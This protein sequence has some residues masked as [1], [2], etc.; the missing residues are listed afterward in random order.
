MRKKLS[1]VIMAHPRRRQWAESLG[2]QLKAPVVYDERSNVWDTC[3]RAWLAQDK[4]AEYGVVIQDDAIVCRDFKRRASKLLRGEPMY[5]FYLTH[6]FLNRAER[7]EREGA[8]YVVSGAVMNEIAL[9]IRMELVDSMIQFCDERGADTDQL[10]GRW[11]QWHRH[12]ILYPI[13]SL[14][15]HRDEES[16]YNQNYGRAVPSR[17]R[18]CVRFIDQKK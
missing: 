17:P 9:C 2:R 6:L 4:K 11:A 16:I 1:I 14:I 8:E 18:R 12:R 7:A 10:I 13:F 3:R 15:D 5:N